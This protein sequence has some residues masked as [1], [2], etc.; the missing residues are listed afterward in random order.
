M[1]RIELKKEEAAFY[2]NQA[3]LNLTGLH[4]FI[5]KQQQQLE[6]KNA[7]VKDKAINTIIENDDCLKKLELYIFNSK[8][9]AKDAKGEIKRL[10][11]KL[12][13]LRHFYSHYVY[14]PDV[15]ELSRG[16]KP[17]LEKYYEIAIEATASADVKLEII[18]NDK[19]LTDAGVLFFLC[20]FLKKSQANKL[21][22]GV[23][24]FKRNDPT[25]Q[26]RRNLFTYFSIREGYKVVPDMQ[27]HFLLFTLVNHLSNQDDYIVNAQ[28]PYDMGEGLFFHRIASTFLNIGGILRNM[29]FYSYQSSRL[30]EQRGETKSDE[31]CFEW[32]EPFQGNSYFSVNGQKGVIGEDELKE[33]CYALLVDKQDVNKVEGRITQ[34]LRKFKNADNAQKVEND[35]MLDRKNFPASYFAEPSVGSIKDKILNRLK[36]AI[37]SKKNVKAY[38]KMKEVMAFINNYLP[39]DEKLKQKDY[40]RYLKM[41]R[42]W[43]REKGNIER[44]FK[45]KKWAKYF[46]SN[47]WMAKNLEEVYKLAREKNAELFNK[48]KAA[49][50]KM[51]EREFE[52]YQQINDAKDLASLKRI[53]Q[54]FG[55]KWEEKNWEE[56]SGQIKKQITDGQKLT[57]MKQRITA[58]LKKKHGIEN[59]NLR[60]TIDRNKSKKAVLN[61]I[62]IPRGF[63]KKHILCCQGPEKVS[64]KIREAG[65]KILLSKKYEE[66][67]KKFFEAK[68]WDKMTRINGLYEKNKLIALMAVYL[69]GQLHIHLNEHTKLTELDETTVYFK[70]SEKVTEKIRLSQYPSLVYAISREYV[71]RISDYELPPKKPGE[72]PYT[73]FEKIDAIEKERMEFIKEVLGFEKYLFE[74]KIIDKS[75]FTDT[76]T[77][78]SFWEIREELIKKD[79]DKG[80]LTE[81]NDAR[82]A[83]LHGKT[84][85]MAASFDE[86]K[87][88]ING[89]KKR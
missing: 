74:N 53:A 25:G 48:L 66:L 75:K 41:V 16:E 71:D 80:K 62:A 4:P 17:L 54:D 73:F 39:A 19:W 42:F 69:M 30:K 50:E 47:F 7:E 33:L 28:Q 76:A 1:D 37:E 59:F 61:R 35:E 18:E 40:R 31:G 81:L 22:S 5:E 89:L 36:K 79:W 70:I 60:I 38:D 15:K 83:A 44:E 58:A 3:I 26:P 67:S 84:P 2:F 27:K 49:V 78:I 77:H 13:E 51:N 24:G 8:D 21:I 20:M 56:Y 87:L 11:S 45:A 55:V 9:V 65:C 63:V 82:N 72:P 88:L 6:S 43:G 12:I 34:F 64:K 14:K 68:D 46:S 85:V 57:I 86:A 10:L 52:K 23:S 29:K 32:I